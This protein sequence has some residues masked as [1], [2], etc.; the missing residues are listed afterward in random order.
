MQELLSDVDGVERPS[1]WE[2][3]RHDWITEV[4]NNK[5]LQRRLSNKSS[6]SLERNFSRDYSAQTI[7]SV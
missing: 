4:M 7:N 5:K 6:P 1:V 2:L 3:L